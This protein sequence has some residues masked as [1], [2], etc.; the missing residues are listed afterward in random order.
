MNEIDR[1]KVSRAISIINQMLSK[2]SD[3]ERSF[4]SARNWGLLDMFG[5]G[6]LTNLIKHSKISSASN[7]M[8]NINYLMGQLHEV[9]GSIRLPSGNYSVNVGGLA[10]FAD[11]FFDG[12]I[13]DTYMQSKIINSLNE[14]RDL[15]ARLEDLRSRLMRL[16]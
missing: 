12:I 13:A 16:S 15:E 7:S 11:F 2:L 3:A 6:T 10:T 4:K 8:S 5:G 14:V 9:L 1:T